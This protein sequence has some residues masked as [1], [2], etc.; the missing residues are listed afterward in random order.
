M[1]DVLVASTTDTQDQ[2]NQAAGAV[3][4][5][6]EQELEQTKAK[7]DAQVDSQEPEKP[8][9]KEA[10][11]E[12]KLSKRVGKLTAQLTAAEQRAA[13]LEAELAEARKA[14][15]ENP[16]AKDSEPAR[17]EVVEADNVSAAD[18]EPTQDQ[19]DTY[20]K[21]IKAQTRW[22]IRQEM[23]EQAEKDAKAE[24][25]AAAKQVVTNYN[26]EV[27]KFKEETDDW[28]EVVGKTEIQ[29]QVGVQNALMELARPDVVYFIAK[30]PEVAKDLWEMSPA[31]AIA[32]VGRIAAKL[33]APAKEEPPA[34]VRKGPDK[35]P[36]TS[37][38][39]P[40]KGLS[41]HSTKSAVSLDDPDISYADWRKMRD[42]QAKARF[43]R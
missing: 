35:L 29:I 8:V 21:W 2:V 19:F 23:R 15:P 31:K 43:R 33:E 9:D 27:A 30:H 42:E 39:P 38:P 25:E 34:T 26:A 16:P 13:T 24:E 20:E 5:P 36:V 22:E 10:R 14:K 6:E 3:Q 37:A 17:A 41:G 12:A 11:T 32:E 40:I 1:G 7:G 18:P 28:D 4:E